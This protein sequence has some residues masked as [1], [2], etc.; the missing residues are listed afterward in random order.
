ATLG[1]GIFTLAAPTSSFNVD[2]ALANESASATGWDGTTL[3]KEGAGNLLLSA[4]NT[5]TGP[6]LIDAGTLTA[7]IANTMAD[8]SAVTVASG[9]T[10]ALNGFNQIINGLSGA[11]TVS[12]GSAVMTA[13]NTGSTTFAGLVSGTGSVT[14]TGPGTLTLSG[15]NTYSGGTTIAAGTLTA[16][17]GSALGTGAVTDNATLDLGFT[18]N[19]S[20][21]NT[22]TGTG[23]VQK[24]GTSTVTLS[25]TGSNVGSVDVQQGTLQFGQTGLFNATGYATQ[26]GATT[27]VGGAS[28]LALTGAFTQAAGSALDVTLGSNNPIITAGTAALD[29]DLSVTGFSASAP[30]SASALTGTEFTV[31]HTTGGITGGFSSVSLGGAASKVDYLTLAGRRTAS[32]L[33]YDVGFG[34]TW[35]AGA[36]LGNGVFTLANGSDTF[37]VDVALSNQAA[38]ATGWSGTDLTKNGAGTLTLSAPNTYTG[39]TIINGGTL[40]T[41]IANTFATSSAVTV[42]SGATLA[43]NGFPQLANDLSGTGSITLGSATLTA[44]NEATNTA[45]AGTISGAGSLAKTGAATLT[46][47]GVNT[48]A[49][50]TTIS[51]G[52]LSGSATS[53]GSGAML[54]NASLVINQPTDASFANP[55]NGTGTF[56]KSGAGSLNLTG[57]GTLSGATTVAAGRLAVNGSLANSAV[58]VQNGAV[59]GGNGTIGRT[60]I[61]SGGTVAPGNSIGTLAV[62]GPFAQTTGSTYQVQ[63]DPGST[64]SDLIRVNGA[65]TLAPGATLDVVKIVPGAYS[66]NSNYTVLTATGGVSGTYT[67]TGDVSGAFYALTDIYDPNNV[68]LSAVRVRNFVDAAQTP[69]EIATA[70]ALQNLPDGNPVKNAVTALATD[71]EA[72][73]AFNQLSGE[74][75]ASI[76][77]ALVEDSRYIRDVAVD[78]VRQSFCMPA[79]ANPIASARL[80][81]PAAPASTANDE[82]AAHQTEP[83]AWAHVLGAWGHVNG[84]GNAATLR[85]NLGGFL[86]G[87]DTTIAQQWRVGVLAGYSGGSFNVDDRSSS[88][89]SDNYHV[90]L[91]GGTQWGNVGV[92][93]G[94]AYTW[95]S[96]NTTRLPAFAGYADNLKD[97]YNAHTVQVFGD[98]GYRMAVQQVALEPFAS[99]AYVNLHTGSVN[100]QGGAAALAGEGGST[101]STFTA[102][103]VRGA[104]DFA[105]GN[106]TVVTA[107]GT[108]GWRHAF[109]N[110]VPTSTLAFAGGSPFVVAGVPI[111]RNAALIEAGLDFQITPKASL[112]VTYGGQFGSGTTSQ[113]VQGTLKVRF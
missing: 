62:N 43:L 91:Y 58:T 19:G 83:M 108:L 85:Q 24:T 36:T 78:R 8:S 49:G 48:Y 98:I 94:A 2:L 6:T 96:I 56:T 63:V 100:E 74:I 20:L 95:H 88:A 16:T 71:A 105:L 55:I 110:V 30:T 52:T 44:N 32:N 11:G 27:A 67:L 9:A 61:L 26:S 102:V 54:D 25:G 89:G 37:N 38:S 14:K 109:G 47:S 28:Q 7:G 111:A 35:Q 45:F 97:S 84:D 17:N 5:Y 22:L 82:C 86:V 4:V 50:G 60:S 113:S 68:Y 12:L 39:Q 64:A 13:N 69:N 66:A 23:L 29:G 90:G 75:H 53:F 103:G 101:N 57:T 34:L 42:N 77:T 112:V 40:A 93:A 21:A 99:V 87:A 3:T 79:A 80:T 65:A 15:A 72:R 76:K 59:L 70:G 41:G 107:S 81:A 1:N 18:A 10:L 106:R 73:G 46:L 33:N 92:R 104:I 51:A 31:V